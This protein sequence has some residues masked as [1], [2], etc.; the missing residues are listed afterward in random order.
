LS[1]FKPASAGVGI[2]IQHLNAVW[3]AYQ[4]CVTNMS[5]TY[6]KG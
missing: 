3:V 5:P 4:S 6:V 1:G 2:V